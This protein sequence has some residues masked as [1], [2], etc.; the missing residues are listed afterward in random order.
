ME[1][2]KNQKGQGLVEYIILVALI[3]VATMGTVRILQQSL[4]ANFANVIFALQGHS[5][6][7]V[8]AERIE[9]SD[10]QK[11]DFSNFMNGANSTDQ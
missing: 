3:G 7:K 2:I 5:R 11:K 8:H 9:D 1:S 4:N 6:H 10:L